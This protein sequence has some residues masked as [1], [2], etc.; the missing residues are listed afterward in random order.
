MTQY[1][2]IIKGPRNVLLIL[3]C[4]F[5]IFS[6]F[7]GRDVPLFLFTYNPGQ[8]ILALVKNLTQIRI[9]T[10]KTILDI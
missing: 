3:P 4:T 8:N 6:V 10:S 1:Q 9:A 7:L 5:I 2:F